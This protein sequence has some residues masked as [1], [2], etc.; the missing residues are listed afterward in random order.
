M[1]F[2]DVYSFLV[3]QV[4]VYHISDTFESIDVEQPNQLKH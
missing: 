3:M 4:I 1:Y 2:L